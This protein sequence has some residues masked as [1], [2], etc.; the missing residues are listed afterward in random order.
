MKTYYDY[1]TERLTS[2]VYHFT[3][4]H[5]LINILKTDEFVTTSVLGSGADAQVN[6]GKFFFFST[7]RSRNQGFINGDTKLVLNGDLLNRK[8]SGVAM[9]YWGH[10]FR[11]AGKRQEMEDRIITDSAT[12]P[13]ATQY[14]M[15]I[16]ILVGKY[17]WIPPRKT[18]EEIVTICQS[19][20][21]PLYFYDERKYFDHQYKEKSIPPEQVKT[22]ESKEY[23]K[24]EI[25]PLYRNTDIAA[26]L[27]WN[28]PENRRKIFDRFNPQEKQ[29]ERIDNRIEQ[30]Y[31]L[32]YYTTDGSEQHW[33]FKELATVML[34]DIHNNRANSDPETRFLLKMLADDLRKTKTKDIAD[35][36]MMKIKMGND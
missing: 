17:S 10:E 1:I 21:I 20:D 2:I 13:N 31:E 34:Y 24:M 36:M 35:Y 23:Q 28:S 11:K 19:L 18:V 8:Y 5:N 29:I 30:L 32:K 33:R 27:S 6:K 9:D 4:T 3:G 15:E 22:E 7:T 12:I 14:I 26:L 25:P 16:H